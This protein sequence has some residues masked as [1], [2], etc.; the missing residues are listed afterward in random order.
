MDAF[1]MS[2]LLDLP[3]FFHVNVQMVLLH[4]CNGIEYYE[5]AP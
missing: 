3:N 2:H 1:L 5:A 4:A